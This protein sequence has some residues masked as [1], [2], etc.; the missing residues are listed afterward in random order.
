MY[1]WRDRRNIY[2]VH[3]RLNEPGFRE[4]EE[5]TSSFSGCCKAK[6]ELCRGTFISLNDFI[7]KLHSA[8]LQSCWQHFLVATLRGK[9][10][11]PAVGSIAKI[12]IGLATRLW[13]SD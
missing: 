13:L 7:F 11:N 9:P 12:T 10:L 8:L 2:Q 3:Y 1:L 5:Q 4:V 6:A